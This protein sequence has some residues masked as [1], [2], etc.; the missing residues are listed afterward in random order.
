MIHILPGCGS[1]HDIIHL[2]HL[3]VSPIIILLVDDEFIGTGPADETM[4]PLVVFGITV[5]CELVALDGEV[6]ATTRLV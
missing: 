2:L 3:T 4:A 1:A 5:A 6:V